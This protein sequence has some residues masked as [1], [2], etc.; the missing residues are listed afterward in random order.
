MIYTITLNP[1]VDYIMELEQ[2]QKGELNRSKAE[3]AFP[4]GKGINVSRVLHELDVE[5][6]ALGFAGGYTGEYIKQFLA[7]EG[8]RS[9]FV[10]V[11]EASRINVKVKADDETEINGS[12]PAIHSEHIEM[13]LEQVSLLG[14]DDM[15]VL[16]GS[17]PSSVPDT[18]YE[19]IASRCQKQG[20]KV[21][22]DAEKSLIQPVLPLRPFLIKP[23]HHELGEMFDV[24][25]ATIEDAIHYGK[26]LKETGVQH[27]MVS[28]AEKGALLLTDDAVLFSSVPKGELKSSVG[29]G[30]STVA[31]FLAG[32]SRG[33]DIEDAF[34]LGTSAGSATAYSIGLCSSEKIESLYKE[35]EIKKI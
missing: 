22:I 14:K 3:S 35:I 8:I 2:F 13:L 6:V 15:V 31:G 19:Q 7:Q 20:T 4:G 34:R 24:E 26:K 11:E 21:I 16:A 30:D 32:L 10:R 17:I 23:N 12:G 5:S 18:F 29:A 28:L 9:D 27:V 25:I 33:W 1:S